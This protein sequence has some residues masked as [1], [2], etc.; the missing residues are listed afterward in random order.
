MNSTDQEAA[1]RA[2]KEIMSLPI[3]DNRRALAEGI[4]AAAIEHS[5]AAEWARCSKEIC[6]GCEAGWEMTESGL[7]LI[8]VD[9][10]QDQSNWYTGCRAPSGGRDD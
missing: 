1:R 5:V 9:L 7:H 8:P 10:R 4:I 2:W 6:G 3:S